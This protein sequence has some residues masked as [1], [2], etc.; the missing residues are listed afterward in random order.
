MAYSTGPLQHIFTH[1]HGYGEFIF[2]FC[3]HSPWPSHD[4]EE[5]RQLRESPEPS[6]SHPHLVPDHLVIPAKAMDETSP[7]SFSSAAH[8]ECTGRQWKVFFLVPI[9]RSSVQADNSPPGHART[10]LRP[11]AM[12]IMLC[13]T[14]TYLQLLAAFHSSKVFVNV[15]NSDVLCWSWNMFMTLG[16]L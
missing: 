8:T 11:N 16:S 7:E 12:P 2:F 5:N 13:K 3:V 15:N 10:S 1:G 9:F 14:C 6:A 4:I